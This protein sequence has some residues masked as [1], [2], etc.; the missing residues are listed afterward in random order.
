MWI[1]G[2]TRFKKEIIYVH[3]KIIATYSDVAIA[4]K[5]LKSEESRLGQVASMVY[6][7]IWISEF[8]PSHSLFKRLLI[9]FCAKGSL[10]YLFLSVH[11]LWPH[12]INSTHLRKVRIRSEGI[13]IELQLAAGPLGVHLSPSAFSQD[14]DEATKTIPGRNARNPKYCFGPIALWQIDG[15]IRSRRFVNWAANGPGTQCQTNTMA[16][17][18]KGTEY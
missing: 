2:R 9:T 10:L 5:N 12:S 18:H 14:E 7:K 17:G 1:L 8:I 3:T 11:S 16:D 13:R 6:E 15:A 4:Y